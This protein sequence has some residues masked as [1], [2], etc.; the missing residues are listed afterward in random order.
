MDRPKT[1]LF[2]VRHPALL[3]Q[4]V[5]QHEQDVVQRMIASREKLHLLTEKHERRLE[6]LAAI[7]SV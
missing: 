4:V 1:F 5:R 7:P 2:V 6:T 3:I